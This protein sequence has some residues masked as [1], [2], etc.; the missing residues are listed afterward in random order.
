MKP[1]A[2]LVDLEEK[3]KNTTAANYCQTHSNTDNLMSNVLSPPHVVSLKKPINLTAKEKSSNQS[4]RLISK[5]SYEKKLEDWH[6]KH[7]TDEP[8]LTVG[9]CNP[10]F[11]CTNFK[12][13][14]GL[15]ASPNTKPRPV[16]ALYDII[17]KEKESESMMKGSLDA[18][19]RDTD[20]RLVISHSS[21]T[22]INNNGYIQG[23]VINDKRCEQSHNVDKNFTNG[24][25]KIM[26]PEKIYSFD[27]LN[28]PKHLNGALDLIADGKWTN[29]KHQHH[30]DVENDHQGNVTVAVVDTGQR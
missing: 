18:T 1:N 19:Q 13:H 11:A 8:A 16:S 14:G 10:V 6:S 12:P 27:Q 21:D 2:L 15:Y 24:E 20:E 7:I 25:R 28:E 3:L 5:D 22:L 29:G 17:C 26:P 23:S 30:N 4:N 9:Y